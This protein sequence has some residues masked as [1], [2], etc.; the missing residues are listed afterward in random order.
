[1][2]E[3][4]LIS[5]RPQYVD[6][7]LSGQKRVEFRK[8]RFR[9]PVDQL[10]VYATAPVSAVVAVIKIAEVIQ[11]TPSNIW[12]QYADVGAINEDAFWTYYGLRS[13]AIAFEI[14]SVYQLPHASCLSE[15]LPGT[16]PPQSFKYIPSEL[17]LR[18][19]EAHSDA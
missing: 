18:L 17:A 6:A 4:V 19:M 9:R 5:I 11:D 13:V 12:M 15:L 3:A 8:V 10:V 14:A 2:S 7:I 16:R 1:M